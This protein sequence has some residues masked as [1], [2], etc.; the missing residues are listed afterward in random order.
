MR[1]EGFLPVWK[2][3]RNAPSLQTVQIL[4]LLW[5]KSHTQDLLLQNSE[6]GVG[7][8]GREHHG[9]RRGVCPGVW[10]G[11]QKRNVPGHHSL[12]TPVLATKTVTY[13]VPRHVGS[14]HGHLLCLTSG[15]YG[16]T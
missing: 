6:G 15:D 4:Q 7:Q 8:E 9:H 3:P 10:D 13:C 5:T 16:W 11:H 1:L 14:E 12:C 2:P